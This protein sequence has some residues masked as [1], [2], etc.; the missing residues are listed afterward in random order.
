MNIHN[1][2]ISN[3]NEGKSKNSSKFGSRFNSMGLDS[4]FFS[5]SPQKTSCFSLSKNKQRKPVSKLFNAAHRIKNNETYL[6][7]NFSDL[8]QTSKSL[9]KR[10][11]LIGSWSY[12]KGKKKGMNI[13]TQYNIKV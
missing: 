4:H 3:N 7:N 13:I 6:G 1:Y 9:E 10:E 2:A 11:N 5:A 12:P 8:H